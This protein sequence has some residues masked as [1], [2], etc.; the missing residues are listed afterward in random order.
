MLLQQASG[1][2][3]K[4]KIKNVNSHSLGVVATDAKTSRPRNAILIP[5]NTPL[6]ASAKRIFKSH[7]EG[8]KTV[9]VTIIEGESSSPED[10]MQIGECIARDLPDN[11]AI[12]TPIEVRFRYLEN[13]RLTITVIVEGQEM[14]HELTRENSLSQE[15]LDS[16]RDYIT[17]VEKAQAE[18]T[19]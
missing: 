15:Q 17:A 16:W 10:C 7:R 2:T 4:L 19:D 6:P 13:G 18:S 11:M 1:D 12:H 9:L 3:T 8:Q 5:R 14:L